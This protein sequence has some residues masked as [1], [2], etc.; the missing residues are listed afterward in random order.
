[1][2]KKLIKYECREE[3][4]ALLPELQRL[5]ERIQVVCDILIRDNY[6]ELHEL[7]RVSPEGK[8]FLR[9][10]TNLTDDADKI[11]ACMFGIQSVMDDEV[12]E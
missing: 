5:G 4:E 1:M 3:L 11:F 12:S 10:I 9:C 8:Y 2:N 7:T 6:L